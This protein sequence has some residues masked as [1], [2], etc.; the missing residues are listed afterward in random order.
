MPDNHNT[1]NL[2]ELDDNSIIGK[3]VAIFPILFFF[4]SFA[5][6]IKNDSYTLIFISFLFFIIGVWTLFSKGKILFDKKT[7]EICRYKKWL[8]F[9][10]MKSI[11]IDNY[12]CV[13]IISFSSKENTRSTYCVNIKKRESSFLSINDIRLKVFSA[14]DRNKAFRKGEEVALLTG[15]SFVGDNAS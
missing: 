10:W 1:F 14:K 2:V 8:W 9:D 15:L 13:N 3:V 6:G 11:P 4:V 5:H 12:E 7:R